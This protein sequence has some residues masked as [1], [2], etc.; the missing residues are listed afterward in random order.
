MTGSPWVYA[1]YCKCGWYNVPFSGSKWFS[2]K[3]FPVCPRCGASCKDREMT[4]G[5]VE[6]IPGA[7]WW[8]LSK[9]KFT[10]MEAPK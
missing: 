4:T 2:D 8:H 10:P 1:D 7:K 5:R 6:K 3:D 9:R